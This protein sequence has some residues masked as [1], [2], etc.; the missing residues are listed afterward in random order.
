[1]NNNKNN[2]LTKF[3]KDMLLITAAFGCISI[4]FVYFNMISYVIFSSCAFL[5]SGISGRLNIEFEKIRGL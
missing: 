3:Q 1:M 5:L 4:I 2:K